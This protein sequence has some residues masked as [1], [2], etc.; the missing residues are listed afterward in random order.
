MVGLGGKQTTTT[1]SRVSRA[2]AVS[3]RYSP[4]GMLL[5]VLTCNPAAAVPARTRP[6]NPIARARPMPVRHLTAPP[7]HISGKRRS[8]CGRLPAA[9]RR[10]VHAF[11]IRADA[12]GFLENSCAWSP[13]H[14]ERRA[15]RAR[16]CEDRK[17]HPLALARI[18]HEDRR[19]PRMSLEI[20]AFWVVTGTNPIGVG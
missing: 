15:V 19:L 5:V 17:A 7:L 9:P 16:D 1:M 2:R 6:G 18:I 12:V 20:L 8:S 13:S 14:R 10:A 4:R 3:R 11:R